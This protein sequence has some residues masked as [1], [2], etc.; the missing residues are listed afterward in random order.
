MYW[1]CILIHP[2]VCQGY[3]HGSS[4]LL[5][6]AHVPSRACMSHLNSAWRAHSSELKPSTLPFFTHPGTASWK[7]Q[8]VAD[9]FHTLA[10]LIL[11]LLQFFHTALAQ[12][13]AQALCWRTARTWKSEEPNTSLQHT[14]SYNIKANL[15]FDAWVCTAKQSRRKNMIWQWQQKSS[16]C[17]RSQQHCLLHEWN[18]NILSCK[19]SSQ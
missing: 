3:K 18:Q 2:H 10:P 1:S 6:T 14:S 16:W 11:R 4:K 8:C 7:C 12:T 17:L 9:D 19:Q 13:I 15:N 5:S